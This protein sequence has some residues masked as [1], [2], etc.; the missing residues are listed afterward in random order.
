MLSGSQYFQ[1]DWLGEGVARRDRHPACARQ[2]RRS[3]D[4]M[5][6][7]RTDVESDVSDVS[8]T[9]GVTS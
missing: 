7:S 1:R 8:I 2:R 5:V 3:H 6:T 4:V 9:A